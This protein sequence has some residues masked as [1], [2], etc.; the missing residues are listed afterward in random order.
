M[1]D[2]FFNPLERY[3]T[4]WRPNNSCE[5]WAVTNE[6]GFYGIVTIDGTEV[7]P[8][9]HIEYIDAYYTWKEMGFT[10]KKTEII[11]PEQKAAEE[12]KA[13]LEAKREELM[14]QGHINRIS[15]ENVYSVRGTASVKLPNGKIGIAASFIVYDS[16]RDKSLEILD[17]NGEHFK[18]ISEPELLKGIGT[19]SVS[20]CSDEENLYVGSF[21]NDYS[22]IAAYTMG[23]FERKWKTPMNGSRITSIA[24]NETQ[25][26][27]YDNE[28]GKIKY[29]DKTTGEHIEGKDIDTKELQDGW[30]IISPHILATTNERLIAAVPGLEIA[31]E[32]NIFKFNNELK[33]FDNERAQQVATKSF[34]AAM[35]S[36]NGVAVDEENGRAFLAIGNKIGIFDSN[37]YIGMIPQTTRNITQL[38]FD[39]QTGW[40]MVSMKEGKGKVEILDSEAIKV[41]TEIS[42]RLLRGDVSTEKLGQQTLDV[43]EQ[44]PY[45]DQTVQGLRRTRLIEKQGKNTEEV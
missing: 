30:T 40:L 25:L 43:Q 35:D 11:T 7:I 13:T 23:D 24:V 36:L 6:E 19:T 28:D 45:I 32:S 1:Y 26:I 31:I 4:A 8:C 29:F 9:E 34:S 33:V 41:M 44:T 16:E 18:F 20:I 15:F 37:G 22:Y 27:A 12:I 17:E 10:T 42:N 14:E 5:W 21:G 2:K 3:K 38:D 39:S